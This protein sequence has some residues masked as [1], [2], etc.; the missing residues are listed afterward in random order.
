L[1]ETLAPLLLGIYIGIDVIATP[2]NS[3]LLTQIYHKV[4]LNPSYLKGSE[5]VQQNVKSNS[6][7]SQIVSYNFLL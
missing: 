4:V 7:L 2:S 3:F 1:A 6:S 5:G